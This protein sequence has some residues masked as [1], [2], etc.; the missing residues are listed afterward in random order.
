MCAVLCAIGPQALKVRT[1]FD[2]IHV[3]MQTRWPHYSFMSA[4]WFIAIS[5]VVLKKRKKTLFFC[6]FEQIL[7]RRNLGFL[8]ASILVYS[9]CYFSSPAYSIAQSAVFSVMNGVIGVK[10]VTIQSKIDM[11]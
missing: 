7:I 6:S 10:N 3:K 5:K 2:H 1:L 8:G 11:T 9:W 4:T